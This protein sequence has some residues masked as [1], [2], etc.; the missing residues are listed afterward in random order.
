MPQ[1]SCQSRSAADEPSCSQWLVAS[2]ISCVCGGGETGSVAVCERFG[3]KAVRDDTE[4]YGEGDHGDRRLG[5][6]AYVLQR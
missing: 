5:G 4:Q 6:V 1:P 2:V 3:G